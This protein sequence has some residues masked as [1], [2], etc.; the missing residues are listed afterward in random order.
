MN[1]IEVKFGTNRT[2]ETEPRYQYDKGQILHL[3]D[4]EDGIEVQ[5]S[6]KS[7]DETINKIVSKSQVEIPDFLLS[8]NEMITA[9]IQYIDENSQTTIRVAHIPVI[10]RTKSEDGI[11]DNDKPTFREE[12][13]NI[14]NETKA[15]AESIEQRANN[16]EFNGEKGEQGPK[17]DKGD[18][19]EQGDK[20]LDGKTPT[21]GIDYLTDEEVSNFK[22]E[23]KA[24][25]DECYANE[26]KR[27]VEELRKILDEN[28]ISYT[29][30]ESLESLVE[31]T[32]EIRVGV[33][34]QNR[35]ISE[36]AENITK[37]SNALLKT[38]RQLDALWK[39]N[40]GISYNFENDSSVAYEKT[41]PSGAK[42][43][44]IK[45]IG[46][47]T[48]VWNQ[49]V[50]N[51]IDSL[52]LYGVNLNCVNNEFEMTTKIQVNSG[53]ACVIDTTTQS[54][55]GHK[56]Y[57]SAE[58]YVP[59]S[60]TMTTVLVGLRK[61]LHK[62]TPVV[63][64]WC[65]YSF[66]DI[67]TE[68]SDIFVV[69]NGSTMEIGEKIKYRNA[70]VFDLTKMFGAGNEP[71]TIED[72]KAMFPNDYYEYNE[73]ELVRFG[74]NEVVEKGR[75]LFGG[76]AFADKIVELG[77]TLDESNGTVSISA[78]K[79]NLKEIF[80]FPDNSKTYTIILVGKNSS[81]TMQV[82]N[83]SVDNK[84]S[85]TNFNK[86]GVSLSIVKNPKKLTGI[87]QTSISTFNYEKCGIFEGEL[88]EADFK[89][90]YSNTYPIPQAILDL[91]GYGDGVSS[92]VYNYVD[93]EN[94]KYHK[95]VG[96][97]DLGRLNWIYST[98]YSFWVAKEITNIKNALC[99]KY[100]LR[101]IQGEDKVCYFNPANMVIVDSSYTATDIEAFKQ[102]LQG[103]ML[104]YELAE[105][106]VIDISDIIDEA[107]DELIE[108]EAGGSLTFKN[109]K[110]DGYRIAILSDEEYI[111]SLAEIGGGTND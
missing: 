7:S 26:V 62:I 4:I 60:N 109:C 48:I 64:K 101:L 97:V 103:V 67:P 108:V 34:E 93:F 59:S 102:S 28:N 31:K 20:G 90:F 110:G 27:S 45:K 71:S 94:K 9:Y 51:T 68:Q 47:K 82:T 80:E 36:N 57:I 38:N 61:K 87:W 72:F 43:S 106:E 56:Y 77:G 40:K 58:I 30:D 49:L 21:K 83:V 81:P 16:G 24:Y 53:S 89:Q 13:Q 104:Y 39:L 37:N 23:T 17:G 22:S 29:E 95:R 32:R 76:K 55:V 54:I 86:N 14:M 46:G 42:M 91:D 74:V 70:Q 79:L 63:D 65:K 75:N 66:L 100:P 88:T 111:V 44:A 2:V 105:E 41:V 78:D 11:A 69:S 10:A 1:V 99:S 19:G 92:D 3:L 8:K 12:V 50:K 85:L 73:G 96:R 5:F 35:R 107:F 84:A 15:I 6:N 25:I 33:E 18:K 98:N 52:I